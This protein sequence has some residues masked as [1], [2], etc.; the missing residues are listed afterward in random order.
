MRYFRVLSVVVIALFLM[1]GCGAQ[2]SPPREKN[3]SYASDK[4]EELELT[5]ALPKAQYVAGRTYYATVSLTNHG[6]RELTFDMGRLFGLAVLDDDGA[7]VWPDGTIPALDESQLE[8]LA[9]GETYDQ[10][11]AFQVA[12]PGDYTLRS[13]LANGVARKSRSGRI[14]VA[15]P[16][17]LV[18]ELTGVKVVA[19]SEATSAVPGEE[20]R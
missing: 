9:D 13:R 14:S 2:K 10:K 5:L 6:P 7:V 1:A 19:A 15:K 4:R 16:P 8:T 20:Q 12:E 11:L 17:A 3:V 18:A